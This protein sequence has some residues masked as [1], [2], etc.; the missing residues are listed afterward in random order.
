MWGNH[1]RKAITITRETRVREV[2]L[3]QTLDLPRRTGP[4]AAEEGGEEEAV[5]VDQV[6]YSP[7]ILTAKR[8]HRQCSEVASSTTLL[9]LLDQT[10]HL[11]SDAMLVILRNRPRETKSNRSGHRGV[12]MAAVK[13]DSVS[14]PEEAEHNPPAG[15]AFL[16]LQN[17]HE[18]LR[19]TTSQY[20]VCQPSRLLQPVRRT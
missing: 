2:S 11:C 17:Q 10:R 15:T 8:Q 13:V 6:L 3:H 14:Q 12:R 16:Q 5:A 1:D 4:E 19:K 9:I 18:T 7:E 20:D